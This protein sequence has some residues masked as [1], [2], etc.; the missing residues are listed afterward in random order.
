MDELQA[1][2]DGLDTK[3][4]VLLATSVTSLLAGLV[5]TLTGPFV[6]WYYLLYAGGVVGGIVAWVVCLRE[7]TLVG[8]D[9][10]AP[11]EVLPEDA[12]EGKK[13]ESQ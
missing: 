9:E 1:E 7:T 6:T 2:G 5:L 11:D 4:K 12:E 3:C 10:D 13:N 8:P